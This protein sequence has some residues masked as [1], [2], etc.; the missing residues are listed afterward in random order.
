M[1]D[2]N[3]SLLTR[4]FYAFILFE[5]LIV[6]I[7]AFQPHD[8]ISFTNEPLYSLN[9]NWHYV[10]QENN[11]QTINLP[12]QL[13]PNKDNTVAISRVLP[14]TMD[15]INSLS[16]LTSQQNIVV[17]LGSSIIYK[18]IS[19]SDTH[20]LNVPIGTLWDIIPL[21]P[22]AEGKVITIIMH[23]EYEDYAGRISEVNAGTKASILIHNLSKYGFGFI[24]SIVIF[25]VGIF[26]VVFY[27]FVKRL[28]EANRS[29]LYLGWFSFIAATWML[30]ES[31][32]TQLFI[33]NAYI[34]A[35]LSYLSLMA[36]PLPVLFYITLIENYHYKKLN[37]FLVNIVIITNVILIILQI[38]NLWD[39]HESLNL[40]RLNLF[41]VLT[42][43]FITLWLDV[44]KH[45]NQE[46]KTFMISSGVL[47]SFGLIELLNYNKIGHITGLYFQIGFILFITLM[48]WGTLKKMVDIVKLSETA[49]H[50]K[51]LATRDPLT[52]CRSRV[53]Y[54]RDF[55]RI[56][57]SRNI[58]IF[59]TD[60][61]NMKEINDTYGHHA[62]DEV[63]I[64]C[65]QCL[66]K[67]F[68]RR[69]YRIGGDE[70]VMIEYDLN[71]DD[72]KSLID[73][74]QLE[75]RRAQEDSTYSFYMSIGYAR[76]DSSIDKNIYDTVKRADRYMYQR[77]MQL[78]D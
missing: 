38:S 54:T 13:I 19:H 1:K 45:K 36:L 66:L 44:I 17:Y 37:I 47:L 31:N 33:E 77:K 16:I 11:V 78:K 57:L 42:I 58:T 9:D 12:I 30:M 7:L 3:D 41:T 25:I 72:I 48:G 26:F 20:L 62:G 18:R 43:S 21:P 39:F 74:F 29:L 71:D 49:K 53:S 28:L 56:D 61:D 69:V 76:F 5:M 2:K 67:V 52:N 64:L 60:M 6:L 51:L 24:V 27:Q 55:E 40:V 59:L 23:S 35:S 15:H 4:V 22:R 63:I 32:L 46:I 14:T 68:G 73:A 10:D 34:M 8:N 75:C 70:F 50:Y 65:S